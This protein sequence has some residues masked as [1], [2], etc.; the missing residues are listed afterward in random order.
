MQI[1]QV[2]SKDLL[3]MSMNLEKIDAEIA[4]KSLC[5]SK[6]QTLSK[7]VGLESE[8]RELKRKRDE[9]SE[10]V[11]TLNKKVTLG[12][13]NFHLQQNLNLLISR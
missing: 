5:L 8:I 2:V 4:N 7:S 9:I 11:D 13:M 3:R 1:L 6:T 12:K 10:K